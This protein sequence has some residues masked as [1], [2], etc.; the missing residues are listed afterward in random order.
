MQLAWPLAPVLGGEE[1]SLVW[2]L[3]CALGSYLKPGA[4]LADRAEFHSCLLQVQS[5][6]NIWNLGG[7]VLLLSSSGQAF[8]CEIRL[9]LEPSEYLWIS[10]FKETVLLLRPVPKT[11]ERQL[12]IKREQ[13]GFMVLKDYWYDG[14]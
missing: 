4:R 8:R 1:I 9:L 12:Q 10:E 11:I 3:P 2:H 6:G 5:L 13:E 14:N 7:V